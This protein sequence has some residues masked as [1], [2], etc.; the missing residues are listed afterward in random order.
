M[1]F[2]MWPVLF[3]L[4]LMAVLRWRTLI[5]VPTAARPTDWRIRNVC[6]SRYRSMIR[7]SPGRS[8]VLCSCGRWRRQMQTVFQ[9]SLCP[10]WFCEHLVGDLLALWLHAD[11]IVGVHFVA[12]WP[13]S[14]CSI[15]VVAISA[16]CLRRWEL[17]NQPSQQWIKLDNL[18]SKS[19][20]TLWLPRR[21]LLS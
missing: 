7:I 17:N 8:L 18:A 2:V 13:D 20:G 11:V 19:I 12:E 3:R 1:S 5:V 16:K 10:S 21:R 4:Q 9:A 15:S 14:P 6:P